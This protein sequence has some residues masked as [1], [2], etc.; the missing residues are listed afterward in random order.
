[1]EIRPRGDRGVDAGGGPVPVVT[2]DRPTRRGLLA[3]GAA[4]L[5]G[6]AGRSGAR[7][8]DTTTTTATATPA[9]ETTAETVVAIPDDRVPENLAFGPDGALYTS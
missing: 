7:S 2:R 1:V 4:A 3:A 5:T 6:L 9:P 8:T